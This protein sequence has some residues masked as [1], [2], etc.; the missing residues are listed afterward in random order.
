MHRSL[1][2]ISL[3]IALTCSLFGADTPGPILTPKP[4]A[5]PRIN[6]A[7][8]V[9]VR[10]GHPVLIQIPATGA[11]PMTYGAENLPEGLTLDSA[12]GQI[13][14]SLA[15]RQTVEVT[16]KA[17]N[18]L[19]STTRTLK[20]IS[21]DRI[22]LTPPLGWNSWNAFEKSVTQEN[23]RQAAD[24]MVTTGLLDHGY[25]YVN[26]DDAWEGERDAE[27]IIQT[28]SK[29][30]DMKGLGQY[31]HAKG[32][33]FGI[34]SSPGPKTCGRYEG[35]YQHDD[36]D[37][38]RFGEWGVDYVKYDLCTY[39]SLVGDLKI[40]RYCEL[41]PERA[42]EIRSLMKELEVLGRL[43][44]ARTK[45]QEARLKECHKTLDKM[46]NVHGLGTKARIDNDVQTEPY[47]KFRA[48]L[49]KVPRDIVYSFSGGPV[50]KNA[51]ECGGNVWRTAGDLK[52]TWKGVDGTGFGQNGNERFA[53]PGNWNDPD[54]LVIGHVSFYGK[55]RPSNLTADEQYTHVSLWSML[56]S[57]LLIGCDLTKIDDFT[58]SLLTNDEVLEVN[59][60][61]LGKQASRISKEETREVWAKDM[62]DGS[63]A[64]GLF[65]RGETA[66]PVTITWKTLGITG[67]QRVRDL[68]RQQDIATSTSDFTATVASHGVV[69]VR[70]IPAK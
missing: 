69:L 68:W 44:S 59:Q 33:K 17:T 43:R 23:I 22:A 16:L 20:I 15:T 52:D 13:T 67:N 8:I 41:L 48:A 37:A 18:A 42:D 19:G 61:P 47:K 70:V 46:L 25:T 4:P 56:C 36:L 55:Q 6:G 14:G 1:A 39:D 66:Q 62:E 2:L 28:N 7:K 10:P 21:G 5:T 11:R 30:P 40:A 50:G 54:M 35:T 26:I 3:V 29:F 65:N 53:G 60:D 27:G 9:G 32:L 57:P 51:I 12:T 34:Y 58:L 45:E 49:D 38:Q 64:V 31:I 24:A 63:K